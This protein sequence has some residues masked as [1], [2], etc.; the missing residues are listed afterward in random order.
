M[1]YSGELEKIW[2]N[3]VSQ[4]SITMKA[5]QE[6]GMPLSTSP[7]PDENCEEVDE[8]HEQDEIDIARGGLKSIIARAE[9]ILKSLENTQTMPA[10]THG[11]IAVANQYIVDVSQCF[12]DKED[13]DTMLAINF[14][15]MAS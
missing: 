11:K 15:G 3:Y 2:E 7:V 6:S 1:K 8:D 12:T 14:V 10:W 5:D 4:D 13:T 9:E